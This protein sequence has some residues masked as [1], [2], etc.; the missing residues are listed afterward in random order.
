MSVRKSPNVE[1]EPWCFC[2]QS[3]TACLFILALLYVY[4]FSCYMRHELRATFD[5]PRP[6]SLNS[7]CR[8]ALTTLTQG[9]WKQRNVSKEALQSRKRIDV[10]LRERKGWPKRLFHG[11][12]R[13]GPVFQLPRKIRNKNRPFVLD[14]QAQCD[15]ESENYCC[16]SNTGWCGHGEKFCDCPSCTNY[17]SFIS[18]ELAQWL[19][20]NGCS[21]TNFTQFSACESI[22]KRV[23]SLTFIGDSL[24]RHLFSAMLIILTNDPLYGA[25]K[26]STTPKMRDICKGDSQFGDSI[27]HVHTAMT[28]RDVIDNPNFCNRWARFQIS[29]VKAYRVEIASLAHLTIKKHLN[30]VGSVVLM[31]IGIHNNFNSTAVVQSYLEPA[32]RLISTSKNGWPHLIW[33]STH[34]TGPLKPINYHRD[35]GNLAISSFNEN[36]AKY[37][38][39]HNIAVF[40]TFNM[41]TGV[42]SFDG[43]HFGVGVNIMKVQILLNYLEE[44]F[45]K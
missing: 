42:H 11:D 18:A 29:Y 26:F 7:R 44:T 32:V 3:C 21:V 5:H 36:I 10:M 12:L 45:S 24:V 30:K 28:W 41:T 27:C 15:A 35:Q 43:T 25:L 37:C 1:G 40:D 31:G 4:Y 19:P 2:R 34:S 38:N 8:G 9:H 20:S 22:S 39:E 33:L 16:H 6:Q 17:K 14:V 23:S 13:C